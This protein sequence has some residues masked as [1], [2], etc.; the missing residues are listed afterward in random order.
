[1]GGGAGGTHADRAAAMRQ[2]A[3][4]WGI[5]EWGVREEGGIGG[6]RKGGSEGKK[7][8]ADC[9]A[10]MRQVPE[11]WGGRWGKDVGGWGERK[12]EKGGINSHAD[13]TAAM[14]QVAERR[15]GVMGEE[16]R[17]DGRMWGEAMGR[18]RGTGGKGSSPRCNV[19]GDGGF[20]GKGI[21]TA[22]TSH[23]FSPILSFSVCGE[24]KRVSTIL[25]LEMPQSSFPRFLPFLPF[26]P[27]L[28]CPLPFSTAHT[29]HSF[30]PLLSF[31]VHGE[32]E[33]DS[34]LLRMLRL[35]AVMDGAVVHMPQ[36]RVAAL[37][38][39]DGPMLSL[40]EESEEA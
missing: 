14:R 29:S 22:H 27:C 39:P 16:D 30:S 34:T 24:E 18:G 31:S 7:A 38:A 15:E 17:E 40:V 12:M 3:E 32:G 25:M 1:M 20:G 4:G 13:R 5:G 26:L 21:G 33:F 9:A 6:N 11:G 23:G 19:T 28:S 37:R 8:Q 10:T 2:V 36:G 35:G